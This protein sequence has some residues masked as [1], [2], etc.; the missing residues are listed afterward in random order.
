MSV[1]TK[2]IFPILCSILIG[3]LA[4][5]LIGWNALSGHSTVSNKI[6]KSLSGIALTTKISDDFSRAKALSDRVLAMTTLIA[7]DVI[8]KEFTGISTSLGQNIVKLHEFA[9]S[10]E[11]RNESDALQKQ[12]E[13]WRK[14]TSVILGLSQ[15]DLIPTREKIERY[16]NAMATK[17]EAINKLVSHDANTQIAAAGSK[18]SA[19]I[20]TLLIVVF[21]LSVIGMVVAIIFA[22]NISKPLLNLVENAERL[23]EGDTSIVFEQQTRKDEIGA[24]ANAIAGFRDGVVKQAEL[25]A[26]AQRERTEQI[27]RQKQVSKAIATFESQANDFLQSVEE[28]MIQTET[29]T[30]VLSGLADDTTGRADDASIASQQAASDVQ[31]AASATRQLN[32]S[33]N[34]IGE[35]ISASSKKISI[36]ADT[37]KQTTHKIDTLSQGANRIGEI[38]SLIQGI[39]EQTNLLALNATIEAARA[40]EAGRGFSVVA[41]EVKS[42]ASQT[43][44][45]TEEISTRISEIQDLTADAVDGISQ[46]DGAMSEVNELT[47]S[48]SSA[49]NEQSHATGEISHSI[50]SAADKTKISNN[51]MSTVSQ[52][53]GQTTQSVGEV[54][55]TA[56]DAK[57]KMQDLQSSVREFLASVRA[58]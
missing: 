41:T 13:N 12:Y 20:K 58:A 51:N 43:A 19:T 23:A 57:H 44:K 47:T 15:S 29:T 30:D 28:R 31:L 50:T 27:A 40:G 22:R 48:I 42:L 35:Q 37:T 14:D 7:H 55:Q 45:A 33:I 24:V 21:I 25:E 54:K 6:E 32:T 1:R 56:T 49:M 18:L 34:H 26:H 46:I 53:L 9:L 3:L 2:I 11:V 16:R 8:D 39:A 4:A 52:A 5:G 17:I 38:V 36:A 10:N